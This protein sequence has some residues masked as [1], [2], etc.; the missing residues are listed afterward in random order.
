M[1][2]KVTILIYFNYLFGFINWWL[3]TSFNFDVCLHLCVLPHVLHCSEVSKCM[4]ATT[5]QHVNC[6][7]CS[8]SHDLAPKP[9]LAMILCKHT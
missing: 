7:D 9:S 2:E 3:G 8:F 1:R 6:H 4:H 5:E